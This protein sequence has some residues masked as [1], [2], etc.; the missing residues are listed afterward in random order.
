MML[1]KRRPPKLDELLKKKKQMTA[2]E[3]LMQVKVLNAFFGGKVKVIG[4]EGGTSAN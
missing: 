4:K 1:A 2:Q 3:M